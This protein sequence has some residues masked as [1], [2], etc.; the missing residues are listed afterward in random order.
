MKII[1]GG[2]TGTRATNRRVDPEGV[3]HRE[4]AASR[5]GGLRTSGARSLDVSP[6]DQGER[7]AGRRHRL[8]RAY[9][10]LTWAPRDADGLRHTRQAAHHRPD[11]RRAHRVAVGS[12]PAGLERRRHARIGE[13]GPRRWRGEMGRDHILETVTGKRTVSGQRFVQHAR[14]RVDADIG[15]CTVDAGTAKRKSRARHQPGAGF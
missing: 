12:P 14:Q 8:A 6:S 13:A 9:C 4:R 11:H 15:T 2:Q 3:A 10:R 1:S 7:R 5:A